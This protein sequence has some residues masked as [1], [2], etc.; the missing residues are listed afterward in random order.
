MLDLRDYLIKRYPQLD[1]T[2]LSIQDIQK[3]DSDRIVNLQI[4]KN[5]KSIIIE[6]HNFGTSYDPAMASCLNYIFNKQH[7]FPQQKLFA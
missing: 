4:K 7:K 5:N 2:I 6:G 3:Q 1:F